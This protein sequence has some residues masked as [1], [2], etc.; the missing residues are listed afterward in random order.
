MSDGS[1]GRGKRVHSGSLPRLD[2][3]LCATDKMSK[4]VGIKDEFIVELQ[5]ARDSELSRE[6]SIWATKSSKY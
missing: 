1:T 6:A 4:S 2:R 3:H 5:E